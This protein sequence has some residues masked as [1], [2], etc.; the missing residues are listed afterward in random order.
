MHRYKLIILL[1]ITTTIACNTND[2]F[3]QDL[4][5]EIDSVSYS[6][7]SFNALQ[8][9]GQGLQNINP[10]AVG[11]GMKHIFDKDTLLISEEESQK[12]LE[13]YFKKLQEEIQ[14]NE[15][16]LK[17]SLSA[18][19]KI[20]I[21]ERI[22]N[23]EPIITASGLQ[24]EILIKGDGESPTIEQE[25]TVHYHGSL[26][27]GTVFDSSI[28]RGETVTF[29]VNGVI[30][31]WVEALQLMSIGDKW[32]ITIPSNLAYGVDG[33]PQAGIPPNSDL[34]FIVELIDIN[35]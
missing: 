25:V 4:K 31:G 22:V 2:N 17:D 8:L 10:Y 23:E 20:W 14:E 3:S 16:R 27:D 1:S 29:P 34:I 26:V 7:G 13:N 9:Q 33:I 28:E 32:K 18:L 24:Y 11:I 21:E 30:P 19:S 12:I 15:L 35:S 6:L 5:N